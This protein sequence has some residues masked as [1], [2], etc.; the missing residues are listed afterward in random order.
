MGWYGILLVSTVYVFITIVL[1]ILLVY[2]GL[3]GIQKLKFE[4][5][6]NYESQIIG[7]IMILIGII[8][9]VLE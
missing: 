8:I 4:F 3:K 9:Y 1:T 2:L 5:L 7:L 6:E